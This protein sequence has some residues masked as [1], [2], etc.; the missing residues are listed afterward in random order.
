LQVTRTPTIAKS[1]KVPS[2]TVTANLAAIHRSAP[3]AHTPTVSRK[4]LA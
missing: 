4:L 1:N 3:N 2:T